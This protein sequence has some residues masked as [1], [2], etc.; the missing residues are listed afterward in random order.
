MSH[1]EEFLRNC[2]VLDTET[3]NRDYKIAEVIE[4]GHVIYNDGDWVRFVEM[5]KPYEPISP[6]VSEVT[7]ITNKMVADKP[8]FEDSVDSLKNII[9]AFGGSAICVAHNSFYDSNVLLRYGVDY[10][11]WLCT[12]RLS[13]KLFGN[14]PTVQFHRLSYLRYRFEIL[15][16]G[17]HEIV[18]H[19]A[20]SDALVTA[21][22]L[23]MCLDKMETD[24][25]VDTDSPYLPQIRDYIEAPIIYNTMPFGKHKGKRLEDVPMDYW[26]WALNNMDALNEDAGNYDKDLAASVAAA[27]EKKLDGLD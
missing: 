23:V 17:E 4:L 13:Q 6:E 18:A 20:D 10:P 1:R 26:N 15:D 3:N 5:F 8:Y 22:F 27:I 14:D 2:I 19:R 21:H 24:G 12:M 25:I 11:I 9:D 7:N 16:P